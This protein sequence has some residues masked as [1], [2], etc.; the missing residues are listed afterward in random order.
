MSLILDTILTKS[1]PDLITILANCKVTGAT[2]GGHN[3]AHWNDVRVREITEEL[4]KR[5]VEIPTDRWL[6]D[7]GTFNGQGAY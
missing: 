2:C 4:R 1:S 3:K 6:Y 7:N 5:G